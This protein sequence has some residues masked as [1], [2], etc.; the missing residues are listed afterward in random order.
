MAP[1]YFPAGIEREGERNP[2]VEAVVATDGAALVRRFKRSVGLTDEA[3]VTA[4]TVADFYYI[5]RNLA[6]RIRASTSATR[7]HVAQEA[8]E[9]HYRNRRW[10]DPWMAHR[11]PEVDFG[12]YLNIFPVGA[13]IYEV[14]SGGGELAEY[15][16][17][18][19]RSCVATE[20]AAT[21]CEHHRRDGSAVE[22]H[23]SDGVQIARYEPPES[24]DY[25]LSVQLLEHLHPADMPAH[26]AN[27]RQILRPGGSYVF[28]TPHRF[29]GP[30]DISGL[31]ALP[32][33]DCFHLKEYTYGEFAV[34]LAAAGFTRWKAVYVAPRALRKIAPVQ[35]RSRAYA[36]ALIGA[37]RLLAK[38]PDAWRRRAVRL[39]TLG[40]VWRN[41]VF[42]I[43]T[44]GA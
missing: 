4:R 35:F 44:R 3:P 7:A 25:A 20:I 22:W 11:S 37:E 36:E 24:Y 10:L 18:H 23:S 31:F 16:T 33:S 2:A 12:L 8:Y 9:T 27:I 32:R 1:D 42:M 40:C 28:A 39:L 29:S 14:G 43:A 5:E 19:G 41:D 13:R 17:Q 21:Q 26:L 38:L 6:A 15:L 30:W 34:L